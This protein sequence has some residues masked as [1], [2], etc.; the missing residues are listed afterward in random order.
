MIH[1]MPSMYQ[2]VS[3]IYNVMGQVVFDSSCSNNYPLADNNDTDTD[4]KDKCGTVGSY[5]YYNLFDLELFCCYFIQQ[6]SRIIL[7]SLIS[8]NN[9]Q[10]IIPYPFLDL[11]F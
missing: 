2:R 1:I 4:N 7:L 10:L 6:R 11:L 9:I 3:L 5:Y 8:T